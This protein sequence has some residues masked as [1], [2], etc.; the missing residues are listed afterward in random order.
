MSM[1]KKLPLDVA[2]FKSMIDDNYLYIDKTQNI[3][4]LFTGNSRYYFFSRPRRFGKSLLI[5]TLKEFF[6]GNKKLFDGL[7]I[8]KSDWEWK[9]HP[10]IHLDFSVIAH[11]TSQEL[12]V[13]LHKHLDRH[14]QY[15]NIEALTDTTIQDKFYSL[16]SELA[17]KNK[18]VILI[19]EYDK[20]II[21]HV[22]S[23]KI[24]SENRAVLKGFYDVIKGLD[25]HLRAIFVT[26]VSKFSKASIFSGINNLND[27]SQKPETASLLGYTQQE[28][29]HNFRPY[30]ENMAAQRNRSTQEIFDE[31]KKWYNGYRF[32][33]AEI[34]VYNPFSIQYYLNDQERAN[35]WFASGTPTFLMEILK[36]RQESIKDFSGAEVTDSELGPFEIE[37]IPLIPLLYQ[38]GYLTIADSFKIDDTNIFRLAYPN[39]EVRESFSRCIL[40]TLTELADA[41]VV[42]QV[43]AIKDALIS[44]NIAKLCKHMRILFAHLPAKLHIPLERYYH[45]LFLHTLNLMGLD[46]RAEEPTDK[47]FID[48]VVRLPQRILV[49]EFKF[50]DST[51]KAIEQIHKKKYYE[52]YVGLGLPI[53][54]AGI[55]FTYK[56]KNLELSFVEQQI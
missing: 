45:S 16:V 52:K 20:P 5:A 30:I 29:E 8:E 3:H 13:S 12:E 55:V 1:L 53:T 39:A 41:E 11:R 51:E 42:L 37:N 47:G 35:Y 6:S 48:M 31:M 28:L 14:A 40:A 15:Y 17:K 27:I 7:W 23:L 4:Q 46:A 18:V 32:S 54:L 2:T 50:N 49:I 24:A 21:D 44:S 43:R 38:T 9:Q 56:N 25:E 34:C 10:V 19:D 36:S 22:T 26:G 33:K